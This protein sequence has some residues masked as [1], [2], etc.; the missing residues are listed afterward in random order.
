MKRPTIPAIFVLFVIFCTGMTLVNC[1]YRNFNT[2][3]SDSRK[4]YDIPKAT[5]PNSFF[6]ERYFDPITL[7]KEGSSDDRILGAVVPH[8][9]LAHRLIA[10][11]FVR[12]Q[13]NPPPLLILLGPNHHNKGA[14]ILTSTLGWQTPFG[15]V[16][17][18]DEVVK[19]LQNNNMT[20]IDDHI[21]AQEHSMGNLM[22][23]IKYY[24]PKTKV[25][26]IIY[27][28]DVS[29][30]EA[31]LMAKQLADIVKY[32]GA[33]IASVDFSHYLT[34]QEAEEKDGETL[35]VMSEGDLDTLFT[36]DDDHLDSPASLG[37]LFLTMESLGLQDFQVLNHTNSGIIIGNDLIETTS[38][39][40]LLFSGY[41]PSAI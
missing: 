25:V 11:V 12:L 23:F 16:E 22:P 5:Y 41:S 2:E 36:M 13:E 34:R 1:S 38:Y 21:F 24:L 10:E 6:D 14:R 37:T 9:L 7:T 27:H 26:P 20:K 32:D 30:D 17:V 8:H 19:E 28:Y 4:N 31:T 39:I 29:K 33:I 15:I 18:N 3:K 40:T 35:K